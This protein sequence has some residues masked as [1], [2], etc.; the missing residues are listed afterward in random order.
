LYFKMK[1]YIQTV[2]FF[3]F[4]KTNIIAQSITNDTPI[5]RILRHHA[6]RE[7]TNVGQYE[8]FEIAVALTAAYTNP[9]DYDQ[10]V[11]K[12]IFT[13]P[14]GRRDT[15]EGFFLQDFDVNTANGNLTSK[16]EGEWRVRFAPNEMG[17]WQY[18]LWIQTANG[19]SPTVTGNFTCVA[20]NVAG[21]IRKNTTA[22]LNFDNGNQY[23]PVGQNLCW[24]S[25]NPYL[26]YSNWLEKMGKAKAN[27]I[28]L[29]MCPWGLGLEWKKDVNT[30]YEGLKKYKQNNA[31]YL[32]FLLEKCRE[33]DIYIMFCLN[34]HGQVSTEVNPNWQDNPF[35]TANGGMCSQPT[36]FFSDEMAKNTH[37]NRLRYIVARWG[38]SRHIVTWELFNEVNWSDGYNTNTVKTSVRNWH[39][40]MAQYLRKIDPFKHLISTSFAKDDDPL[41]WQSP[42]ID[43]TQTHTYLTAHNIEKAIADESF[44]FKN[45][46]N[47]PNFN[48]EFSID[49]ST[50]AAARADDPQGVH[51][52]NTLW[53][54]AMSGAMGA[55]ATWW[56]DTYIEPQNLYG[57]FTPLSIFLQKVNLTTDNYKPTP[58]TIS[59]G[60]I[61]SD[62]SAIPMADWGQPTE[63]NF[64]VTSAGLSQGRLG[65]YLYGSSFNTQFRNPPTFAV[66]YPTEGQFKVRTAGNTGQSPRIS[67][68]ID[69]ILQLDV[70][71]NINQIYS[72]TVPAGAHNIKVDNLGSDWIQI[73]EYIFTSI[74]G[75]PVNAYILKSE[76]KEKLAGWLHNRRYNWRE[77]KT[78]IPPSV[79]NTFLNIP[80]MATGQY[81]IQF[82][83]CATGNI[84][85]TISVNTDGTNMI[86]PLP[87]LNW[88]IA[89]TAIRTNRVAT[90]DIFLKNIKINAY[91]NPIQIGQDLT[92]KTEELPVGEWQLHIVNISG[93]VIRTEK[94]HLDPLSITTIS[95][96]DI[97]SGIYILNLTNGKNRVSTRV[98]LVD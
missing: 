69:G 67:I 32:D 90:K 83:S 44:K 81:D 76:N 86:I 97:P 57:Y 12:A 29:W 36:E 58:A 25:G 9:Y 51:I 98:K 54:T 2:L 56:W 18:S 78:A 50:G 53:A 63:A 39:T 17:A 89:F 88:D 23:I 49:V 19:I 85:N 70:A 7:N 24:P 80:N 6:L 5:E 74:G 4:I 11:L 1:K 91:P 59:G 77:L 66:N 33:Q 47:K 15:I 34:Y 95:T 30:G 64:T 52:H 16:G 10:V 8:K 45:E 62:I 21:F 46:Y 35:N 93:Q 26:T 79:S 82:Y 37:K 92:L 20:S 73:S 31:W 41:L 68:Y 94:I 87:S 13:A 55:G 71:A 48:G 84:L 43:Y 60:N 65:Q 40:E 96:R 14:S 75:A 22:Y 27:F 38:Y 42:H 3:L 72:I 61:N 28:R